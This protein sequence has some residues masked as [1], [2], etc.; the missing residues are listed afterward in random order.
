MDNSHK[1]LLESLKR[2]IAFT[3]GNYGQMHDRLILRDWASRTAIIYYSIVTIVYAL[4][5]AYFTVNHRDWL[6]F[7]SICVSIVSLAA[8]FMISFAKYPERAL[9]AMRALDDIKYLKKDLA[10]YSFADLCANNYE[11]YDDFIK[12][13]HRIVDDVELR[14]SGDYYRTCKALKKKKEYADAWDQ[15][16]FFQKA[17]AYIARP[18]EYLFYLFLFLAPFIPIPFFM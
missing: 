3:A 13:Y 17:S 1:N 7:F 5:S 9:K 6:D 15:L 18:L 12:R 2:D 14:A 11:L 4:F 16:S 10:K 8:S